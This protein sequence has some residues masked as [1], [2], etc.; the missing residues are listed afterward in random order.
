MRPQAM[1]SMP[2]TWT[3]GAGR[4]AAEGMHDRHAR[5]AERLGEAGRQG[6]G[7]DDH[8]V[9]RILPQHPHRVGGIGFVAEVDQQGPQPPVLQP[10][11]EEVEHLEEQRVVEVVR[12]SP[13]SFVRPVVSDEASAFGL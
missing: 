10:A 8:A 6:R 7:G 1:L 12:D 11:G 3:W 4:V 9:D 13:I 2:T 5:V